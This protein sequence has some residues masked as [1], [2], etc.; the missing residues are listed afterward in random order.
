[1]STEPRIHYRSSVVENMT[2]L[3]NIW[4]SPRF[5]RDIVAERHRSMSTIEVRILWTLGSLG[6]SRS[7]EIATALNAGAPSVSKALSRLQAAE[8]VTREPDARDQRSHTVHLTGEGRAAAQELYDVGDAM[9]SEIFS[10][11]NEADVT[12]LS[13]LLARFVDE[14]EKYASRIHTSDLD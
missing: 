1:V 6:P 10:G 12:Q 7:S 13:T 4:W 2:T 3:L 8:L 14:S 5:Q 11:W 9:V